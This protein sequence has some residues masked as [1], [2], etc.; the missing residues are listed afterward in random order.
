MICGMIISSSTL[1]VQRGGRNG[2]LLG[3]MSWPWAILSRLLA[4]LAIENTYVHCKL[5][6]AHP[7]FLE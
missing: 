5:S 7:L 6:A 3:M 4:M 2:R 1:V